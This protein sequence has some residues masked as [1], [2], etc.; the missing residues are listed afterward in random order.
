VSRYASCRCRTR[1]TCKR[2]G[3]PFLLTSTF[4][5]QFRVSST[6]TSAAIN[7]SKTEAVESWLTHG[8]L[9]EADALPAAEPQVQDAVS[10]DHVVSDNG[11]AGVPAGET[12]EEGAL[13]ENIAKSSSAVNMSEKDAPASSMLQRPPSASDGIPLAHRDR[14]GQFSLKFCHSMRLIAPCKHRHHEF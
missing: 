13:G 12:G 1:R 10:H 9:G 3:N 4:S 11:L 8:H 2:L 6:E 7:G 14:L 5:S